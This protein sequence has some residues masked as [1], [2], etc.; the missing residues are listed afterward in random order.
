MPA[1]GCGRASARSC[2]LAG[3]EQ[4]SME[5][6]AGWAD[7]AGVVRSYGAQPGAVGD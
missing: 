3:V 4:A 6:T 5:E 2:V 1:I 7:A